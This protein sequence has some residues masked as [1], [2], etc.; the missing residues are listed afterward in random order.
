MDL[1]RTLSKEEKERIEAHTS[2][3]AKSDDSLAFQTC[4]STLVLYVLSITL[5]PHLPFLLWCFLRSGTLSRCMMIAHDCFHSS[6]WSSSE[7]NLIFGRLF[8]ALAWS[9]FEHWRR[10][11]L[12]HHNLIGRSTKSDPDG[13]IKWTKQEFDKWPRYRRWPLRIFR[14]PAVFHFIAPMVMFFVVYRLP[15]VKGAMFANVFKGIELFVMNSFYGVRFLML[16]A[17]LLIFPVGF[18]GVVLSQ[19]QHSVNPGYWVHPRNWDKAESAILGST[20]VRIPWFLKWATLGIEYHHIHHFSTAIP[21]YHL[22]KCHESAPPGMWIKVTVVDS[23]RSAIQGCF[24]VQWNDKTQRFE[25]FAE[26]QELFQQLWP[27]D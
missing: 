9:P 20:Y 18:T 6:M 11:H 24:N 19:L 7:F 8:S 1:P 17:V 27:V 15:I 14:D 13:R 22:A 3:F 25:S 21:C 4:A 12:I 23:I 2:K 5:F 10:V 26:Y 16:D